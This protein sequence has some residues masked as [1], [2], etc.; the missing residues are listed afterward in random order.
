MQHCNRFVAA[1]LFL[2]FNATASETD[3]LYTKQFSTCMQ[4]SGGGTVEMLNCIATEMR[5]QDAR[6]NGAY[7]KLVG[8]LKADRKRQLVEV[9]RMWIKY[10]D[11]NCSFY[12]DPE[13]GT[14]A[15]V[16]ASDCMLTATA[17]RAKELEN[18]TE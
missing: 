6:L 16:S 14:N 5:T 7:K 13:G 8:Q 4:K 18:L 10:R 11:A 17:N 2:S 3:E 12:A 15:T 9:Q 1:I